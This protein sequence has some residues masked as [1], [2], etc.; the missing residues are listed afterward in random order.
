M[1]REIN[2]SQTYP[3]RLEVMYPG[4]PIEIV[5]VAGDEEAAHFGYFVGDVCVSCVSVFETGR[6]YQVRKFATLPTY[7]NQGIG[8]R[9]LSFVLETYPKPIFLNARVGK[10]GYYS[11]FGFF[12]TGKRFSKN[13]LDY[14]IMLLNAQI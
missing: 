3:I 12:E 10:I 13:G 2:F 6:G 8:S 4:E 1:I 7:Q 5:K 9:L 11:R 14:S